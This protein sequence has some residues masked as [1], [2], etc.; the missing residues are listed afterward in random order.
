MHRRW[1]GG[2][3]PAKDGSEGTE[4]GGQT[5]QVPSSKLRA[6]IGRV[7]QLTVYFLQFTI[8]DFNGFNGFN[9]FN[10]LPLT[11]YEN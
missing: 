1:D 6:K 7:P 11:V 8:Y 3:Q 2:R 5:I 4:V 9:D 10:D